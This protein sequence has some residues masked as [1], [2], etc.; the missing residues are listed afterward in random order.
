MKIQLKR[1]GGGK[2][3]CFALNL[4]PL[5]KYEVF[6]PCFL[7]LQLESVIQ[8]ELEGLNSG[9]N[10]P[11]NNLDLSRTSTAKLKAPSLPEPTEPPPPPPLTDSNG[12]QEPIYESVLPRDDENSSPPPL[13]APP[14]KL[15]PKSPNIER[16]QR[17]NGSPPVSSPRHSRPSSRS[18]NVSG[19][20]IN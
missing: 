1:G 12:T 14:H 17:V 16:V 15:R 8:Q 10:I 3:P 6:K 5:N 20:S 7:V 13:P 11:P 2:T 4:L 18:S 19:V 9:P